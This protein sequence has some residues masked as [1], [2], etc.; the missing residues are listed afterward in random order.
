MEKRKLG[1]SK[2]E[3]SIVGVGCN[4]FGLRTDLA[5]TR[6]VVDRAIDL[7]I[8]LFD[9]ADHYVGEPILV[10]VPRRVHGH[11]ESASGAA[12]LAV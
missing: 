5:Q 7:G 2:L 11:A 3:V 4:N 6:A 1:K 10:R 8:T 9:C 12:A